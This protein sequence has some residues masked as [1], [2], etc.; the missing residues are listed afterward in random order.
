MEAVFIAGVYVAI[1]FYIVKFLDV[2]YVKKSTDQ[3]IHGPII[4]DTCMVYLATVAGIYIAAQ[5]GGIA[6]SA[7]TGAA[8]G[9]FIG[10]PDF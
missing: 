10:L 7:G 3:E 1:V 6:L 2:R 4:R 5:V 8:K 9:A